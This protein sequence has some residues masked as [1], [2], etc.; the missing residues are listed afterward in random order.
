MNQTKT[1]PIKATILIVDDAPAILD[2]LRRTLESEGYKILA[3]SS[4]EI[5]LQVARR[6]LPHLI[7]LDIM[8]PGMDGFETCRQLKM[9]ES[10]SNIPVIFITGKG[11]MKAIVEGFRAGG[12]DY[13][14]KPFQQREVCA[15]VETHLKISR[16]T[17]ELIQKNRDLEQEIAQRKALTNIIQ[18]MVD[19][20]IVVNPDAT[21]KTVNQA[22]LNLLG[23]EENELI[24]KPV[25]MIFEEEVVFKELGLEDLIKKES[26][27]NVEKT[28]LSKDGRKIPVLFSG[29]VMRDDDGKIQGI[30][31]VVL[32]ITER[33]RAEEQIKASLEEKKALLR[34]IHHRVKNNM[35]VIASLLNIQSEYIKDEQM[36]DIFQNC[37]NRIYAMSLVHENLYLSENLATINSSEYI[38]ALASTLFQ[39]YRIT[40]NIALKMDVEDV[41]LGIDF[42][43]PCGLILNELISNSLK[44]AF[45]GDREGEIRIALHAEGLRMEARVEVDDDTASDSDGKIT[46]IVS[47]NGVE[48]PEDLDFRNTESLGLQLVT[49]LAEDQLDG[50]IELDRSSGTAF[51]ITFDA[52]P[53]TAAFR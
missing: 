2:V 31:C 23:Y 26:V 36:L 9:E 50:T 24:G 16:L 34:E 43:I 3:A 53:E 25:S 40:G 44:H 20:L 14:I 39:T 48:F 41:S 6:A 49:L 12:V 47:N 30:V 42:A 8:M 10:T 11:E 1:A 17:R 15:R 18:S 7:L 33:K 27:R 52:K 38:E 5:A 22:T 21:I 45:P 37:K 4:G 29:S 13:I 46:L 51:K 35:Q 28:Y 32:D 19:T